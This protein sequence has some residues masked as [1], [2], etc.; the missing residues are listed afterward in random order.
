[1]KNLIKLACASTA[2]LGMGL[3]SAQISEIPPPDS[4][5]L[6]SSDKKKENKNKSR[7]ETT[8]AKETK[9]HK[10][11]TKKESHTKNETNTKN[12]MENKDKTET[13][14]NTEK[15]KDKETDK[16]KE[17]KDK[18]T[19]DETNTENT[20]ESESETESESD[21]GDSTEAGE[22]EDP[23]FSLF[24]LDLEFI[25]MKGR[26]DWNKV[27]PTRY[28]G[29]SVYFGGR[30]FEY[31]GLIAGYDVSNRRRGSHTFQAGE[32]FFGVPAL[33]GTATGT[34]LTERIRLQSWYLDLM[35]YVPLT[36]CFDLIGTVGYGLM[37]AN[38]AQQLVGSFT[39]PIASPSRTTHYASGLRAGVGL[40]Y[41]MTKIFGVRGM[42]RWKQTSQIKL[43]PAGG[44]VF[45][46]SMHRPF[47]DT[48]SLGIGLYMAF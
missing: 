3:P 13:D 6:L 46:T 5:L 29:G 9:D 25:H 40:Q 2:I 36:K 32:T 42:V 15:G 39:M 18:E 41:M 23:M 38:V 10:N 27:M 1:M 37:W 34:I 35:G 24:G 7:T 16:D 17:A 14:K 47:K 33:S 31:F 28:T 22:D 8:K 45:G 19:K 12:E 48:F 20:S 11:D 4:D 21:S 43:S 44:S 26:H 30:F